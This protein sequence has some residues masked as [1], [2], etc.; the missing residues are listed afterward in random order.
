M[1]EQG[2]CCSKEAVWP[3][4][5]YAEAP[6]ATPG[7]SAYL[8]PG[9]TSVNRSLEPALGTKQAARARVTGRG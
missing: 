6:A 8:S 7:A 4:L 3:G 5:R 1:P 2:I 9:H